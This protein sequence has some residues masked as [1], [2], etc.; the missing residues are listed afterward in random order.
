VNF[1]HL[2]GS[3]PPVSCRVVHKLAY[4]GQGWN[5]R[6]PRPEPILAW[7]AT[8]TILHIVDYFSRHT[9][10]NTLEWSSFGLSLKLP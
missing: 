3:E 8:Q 4:G 7:A 9:M 2:A 6:M 1:S 10:L 5:S